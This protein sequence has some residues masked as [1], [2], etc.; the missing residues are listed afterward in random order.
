MGGGFTTNALRTPYYR[1]AGQEGL[2]VISPSW[3]ALP[4]GASDDNT[5]SVGDF[6]YCLQ[7]HIW[8]FGRFY[9]DHSKTV[10]RKDVC[11]DKMMP[12]FSTLLLH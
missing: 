1:D 12:T 3:A 2:G 7:L 4:K 10:E 5:D 8:H 11:D 9:S 6:T